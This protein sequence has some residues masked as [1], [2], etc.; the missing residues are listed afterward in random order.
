MCCVLTG[1]SVPEGFK[2]E[3]VMYVW[4]DALTSYLTGSQALVMV[5][6]LVMALVMAFEG[7]FRVSSG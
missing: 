7:G 6:P 5:M 2:Q 1:V 3:H 4:F